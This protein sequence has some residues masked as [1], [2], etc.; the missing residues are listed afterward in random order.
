MIFLFFIFNIGILP[1]PLSLFSY[2]SLSGRANAWLFGKLENTLLLAEL[3]L[4]SGL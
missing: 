3:S 4:K 2:G 1:L